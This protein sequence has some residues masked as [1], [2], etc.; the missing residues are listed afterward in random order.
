MFRSH[1]RPI[2]VFAGLLLVVIMTVV[3]HAQFR[4]GVQG[5]V[6]DSSGGTVS[7]ATVT[8]LNKETN[9][10]QKTETSEDAFYRFSNLAP[11]AYTVS[12]EQ[13]GFKKRVVENLQVDA[14]SITPSDF[15][16]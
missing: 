3:G 8:L 2:N 6:T 1:F 10:A 12:V 5:T 9:Q 4:A 13:P 16:F 7:G 11:G 15:N 14:E